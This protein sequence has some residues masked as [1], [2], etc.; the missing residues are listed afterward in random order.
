MDDYYA[1]RRDRVSDLDSDSDRDDKATDVRQGELEGE[2]LKVV[3]IRFKA[4]GKVRG[5]FVPPTTE[6]RNPKKYSSTIGYGALLVSGGENSGV[7]VDGNGFGVTSYVTAGGGTS[8]RLLGGEKGK[9]KKGKEKKE[10]EKRG[11]YLRKASLPSLGIAEGSRTF[12]NL[13]GREKE[14]EGAKLAKPSG[15]GKEKEKNKD[16][17]SVIAGVGT[18]S[19][20]R[21]KDK[22]FGMQLGIPGIKK[23]K[24]KRL[25]KGKGKE[26]LTPSPVASMSGFGYFDAGPADEEDEILDDADAEVEDALENA[27]VAEDSEGESDDEDDVVDE[28][29]EAGVRSDSPYSDPLPPPTTQIIPRSHPLQTEVVN[30]DSDEEASLV[31]SSPVFQ[32]SVGSDEDLDNLSDERK[33][34]SAYRYGYQF[35]HSIVEAETGK[36]RKK[37]SA[38]HGREE[39]VVK[40]T[41]TWQ[42]KKGS[43][44]GHGKEDMVKEKLPAPDRSGQSNLK[45]ENTSKVTR[46]ADDE[47]ERGGDDEAEL[48]AEKER[49]KEKA[50][51][52]VLDMGTD[53][54]ISDSCLLIPRS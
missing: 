49:T 12:V 25:D 54:G 7:G 16:W 21:D 26:T 40:E 13:L 34:V 19:N 3:C 41:M 31:L 48:D 23:G 11:P 6:P 47:Q 29:V 5:P 32:H 15:K 8:Q 22:S 17:I 36:G 37:G 35:Q 43:S 4:G 20:F 1:R 27:T 28:D 24:G 9:E 46:S 50:E 30:L 39:D 38:G 10:K 52:I 14:K 53:L 18:K 51:W 42:G 2:D 45:R 33:K 44:D